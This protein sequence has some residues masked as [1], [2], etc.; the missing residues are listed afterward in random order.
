MKWILSLIVCCV[1]VAPTLA[2]DKTANPRF[3]HWAKF[4]PG[5]KNLSKGTMTVGTHTMDVEVTTTLKELKA[6]QLTLETSTV[7]IMGQMRNPGH[8]RIETVKAELTA[9]EVGKFKLEKAGS[10]TIDALGKKIACDI[11]K[12][13]VPEAQGDVTMTFWANSE[14]PGAVKTLSDIKTAKGEIVYSTVVDSVEIK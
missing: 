13:T 4:K 11:Y 5:S 8:A 1:L 12:L 7:M 10:E 2:A 3:T 9:E 6:D 14:I